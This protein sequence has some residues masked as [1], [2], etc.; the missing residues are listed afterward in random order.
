M[1]L[2][3]SRLLGLASGS[4]VVIA[5]SATGACAQTPSPLANWQ[6]SVGELLRPL[7]GPEPTWATYIGGG[8]ALQPVFEGSNHYYVQPAPILEVHYLDRAFLSVGEG[9]GVNILRGKLYRA[10][11]AVAY[12]LGRNQRDDP[13]LRGLGNI[14]PAPEPKLFADFA[15]L[16]L[17]VDLDIRHGIAGHGGLIGD[18]GAHVPVPLASNLF[19]FPG[20]S[21]TF[22]DQHYMQS[23]FRVSPSQAAESGLLSAP[24][25]F[26]VRSTTAYALIWIN[27]EC[28]FS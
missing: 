2:I 1:F 17:I 14:G 27:R 10:G 8:G 4:A 18:V 19:V 25:L 6:F 12:D 23:Y 9:V 20:L 5:I 26:I 15:L 28:L 7:M 3:A 21:F 22:A 11:I 13:R 16:P 24:S